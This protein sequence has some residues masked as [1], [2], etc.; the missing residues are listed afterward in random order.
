[1]RAYHLPGAPSAYE[2]DH[3]V[4]LSIGGAPRDPANLW[5]EPRN[6]PYDAREKDQLETWVAR[7]ACSGRMPLAEL[8]RDMAEDWTVL[9]RAAGGEHVLRAYRPGG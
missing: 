3:L 5:P 9:F 8:Q 7:T 4:A 1:M 6:G 2:E